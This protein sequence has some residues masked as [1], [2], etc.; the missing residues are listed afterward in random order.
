MLI[1][2]PEKLDADSLLS[3]ELFAELFAIEDDVSRQ[4]AIFALEKKAQELKKLSEF[5]KLFR[6][7]DKEYK[8]T[9]KAAII[10][11]GND[12]EISV[13]EHDLEYMSG[14]WQM[15]ETGI[16]TMTDKGKEYACPHPIVPVKILKGVESGLCKT[17]L[18]FKVRQSWSTINVNRSMVASAQKIVGLS[19][20][21]VQ[22]TSE[23]SKTLVKYLN[24]MEA[25]N[26]DKITEQ[27]STSKLGWINGEFMPYSENDIIFDND[28]KLM[29]LFRSIHPQGDRDKWM[30]LAKEI[31]K[32]GHIEVLI[33]MAASLAS[34]L[35]E[36][37]GTLPFIV[38]LWGGTG[39]GKTVALML[40]TSIW[41]D[42]KEGAYMS[43]AKA[44]TTAMEIRLDALNSLPLCIDDM[45][46]ISRQHD[47]DFSA[48]IYK[49]CAGKGRDRS[50]QQLGLNPLTKWA[51]C[52]LT[53]GERSLITDNTQ[54]GASNRVIDIEIAEKMFENGNKVVKVLKENFGYCGKEFVSVLQQITFAEINKRF[55]VLVD[56][57]KKRAA[58]LNTEKEDKQ[59][60]PLAL[61][62]LAD[63]ISEE[64]IYKDG[65]RLDVDKCL[66]YLKNKMD[67][68]ENRRALEYFRDKV[69]ENGNKFEPDEEGNYKFGCWGAWQ[70]EKTL[71]ILPTVFSR[72]LAEGGFQS[73]S[74]LS[75]ANR[76]GYIVRGEGRN[77][78][79]KVEIDG[80]WVRCVVFK[81][82]DETENAENAPFVQLSQEELDELPFK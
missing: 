63:E 32:A 31:R 77:L 51:N 26:P 40:A 69:V 30:K 72:M 1:E 24:D 39:L 81:F 71:A 78:K 38:S 54:G 50:N 33:Y 66:D 35:V 55:D 42:P 12:F 62:L 29:S 61:I 80:Q 28:P 7:Y 79:R 23:N 15:D 18:L 16:F 19:E 27:L 60:I 4:R 68:N 9:I 14:P 73:E 21:G 22:V 6:L 70:S 17:T 57:L 64:H 49:W 11:T 46:Q 52:T 59:I 10:S 43:D 25:L 5:R 74:F 48:I 34:V 20:F 76:E 82:R 3:D 75:W 45:A 53:N 67:I 58:E 8:K 41:A 13:P 36:P 65:I 56:G 47:E 2:Y 37:C 44:T